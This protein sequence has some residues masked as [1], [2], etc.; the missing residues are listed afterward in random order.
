MTAQGHPRAIFQRAIAGG[1]LALAKTVLRAE[2]P[3]PTLTDL[4]ELTALQMFGS[5]P[6]HVSKVGLPRPARILR[7]LPLLALA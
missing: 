4:L 1:N 3:R 2:I 5:P 6:G 7:V